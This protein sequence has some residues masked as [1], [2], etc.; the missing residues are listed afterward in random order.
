MGRQYP[1]DTRARKDHV[2]VGG[3]NLDRFD[4]FGKVDAVLLCK[5][6]PLIKKGKYG[7]AVTVFDDFRGFRLY[8]TVE[9]GKRE[10]LDVEHLRQELDHPAAGGLVDTR[11]DAPE[12]ADTFNVFASRHHAFITVRQ[13][14]LAGNSPFFEHFFKLRVGN[15][16]GSTRRHGGFDQHQAVGSDPFGNGSERFFERR[17]IGP[18]GLQIAE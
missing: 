17:H 11:T 7:C 18:A 13:K 4:H 8:R 1:P 5:E 6:A 15:L 14:R 10:I 3:T 2:T 16:L 12:V 9:H